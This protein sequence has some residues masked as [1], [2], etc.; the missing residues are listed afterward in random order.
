MGPGLKGSVTTASPIAMSLISATAKNK[1]Y[2]G[3]IFVILQRLLFIKGF[4]LIIL[5]ARLTQPD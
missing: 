4:T 2:Q 3:Q 5:L 1:I